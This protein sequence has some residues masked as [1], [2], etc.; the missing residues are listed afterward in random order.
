MT[1][2]GR[3]PDVPVIQDQVAVALGARAAVTDQPCPCPG[4]GAGGHVLP[5]TT[6][7]LGALPATLMDDVHLVVTSRSFARGSRG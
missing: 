4:L 3:A 5:N 7:Q 1:R 6:A 2:P